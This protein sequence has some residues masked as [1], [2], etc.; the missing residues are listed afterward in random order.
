MTRLF[1]AAGSAA[2]TFCAFA[3][4]GGFGTG[5]A[6][7]AISDPVPAIVE[8]LPPAPV[9][10]STPADGIVAETPVLAETERAP[11]SLAELVARH[12]NASTEDRDMNCL[13]KA[14]YFEAKGEPLG[15]Q[16]AVAEVIM[17]RAA[18]GRFSSTICGVVF[19]PS[20]FSFVRGG[21]F[22]AIRAGLQWRQAIGIAHVALN[23]LHAGPAANALYFHARRVSPN[24]GKRHVAS[25]GNHIFYR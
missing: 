21:G 7:G 24:W 5:N 8:Q 13:A 3:V 11:A 15:G 4:I 2:T 16:L 18:S 19:Q 25:V 9:V 6:L 22:P 23:R 17:N 12:S 1:R 14:V 20:Q 10:E